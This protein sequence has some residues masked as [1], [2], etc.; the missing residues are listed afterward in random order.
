MAET[1]PTGKTAS[2][3]DDAY[4]YPANIPESDGR[5][6]FGWMLILA[7]FFWA[8]ILD[9]L[10][11]HD[12]LV[13]RFLLVLFLVGVYLVAGKFSVPEGYAFVALKDGAYAGTIDHYGTYWR[14]PLRTLLDKAT[15]PAH[16]TC[17]GAIW[18]EYGGLMVPLGLQ[19]ESCKTTAFDSQGAETRMGALVTWHIESPRRAALETTNLLDCVNISLEAVMGEAMNEISVS[20]Y[21]DPRSM[22]EYLSVRVKELL[23]QELADAGCAVDSVRVTRATLVK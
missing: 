3:Y 12:H 1:T 14:S 2:K 16:R 21:D 17:G 13:G 5:V 7:M 4:E 18:A 6:I 11:T 19:K 9:P 15:G 23:N 20:D 8:M 22:R 10:D